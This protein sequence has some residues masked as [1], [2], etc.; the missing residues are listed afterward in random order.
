MRVSVAMS[1]VVAA[2][3]RNALAHGGVTAY[4]IDGTIYPGYE[5]AEPAEGQKD[6]IQRSW[7]AYPHENAL[8]SNITCNYKG[9]TVS[10]AFH[11]PVQ[12]GATISTTW[13]HDGF[14]WVHTIGPLTAYLASCGDDCTSIVDIANLEWFKIAEEGLREGYA[15]GNEDGW[16]QN[17]LWENRRTDHWDVVVPVGLKP[18]RYM[19]RHEII[20]LQLSPVQFYPNC[21]QLEVSGSGSSV[22]SE[23]YL[24]KFPGAYSMSDPGIAISGKVSGDNVT[25]NYTIPGPKLWTG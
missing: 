17:D 18:G 2:L 13:S 10:G 22:P 12:A 3:S 4:T 11:A 21:A 15:V 20:N 25:M 14:G 7:H 23:E 9:A 6:L 16:F 19:V 1:L 5:W 8:S 24:V